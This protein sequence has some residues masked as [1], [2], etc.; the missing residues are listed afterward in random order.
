MSYFYLGLL[1]KGDVLSLGHYLFTYSRPF[2][3][4]VSTFFLG[5]FL[6]NPS[7]KGTKR[8]ALYLAGT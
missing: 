1:L 2:G 7:T 3:E 5:V 4:D 8:G 6:A